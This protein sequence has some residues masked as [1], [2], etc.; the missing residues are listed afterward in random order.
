M[1]PTTAY[2]SIMALTQKAVGIIVTAIL[3]ALAGLTI[4]QVTLLGTARDMEAQTFRSGV[5]T[6][7]SNTVHGLETAE[8]TT[9]AFMMASGIDDS[10]NMQVVTS[11]IDPQ[12]L[13]FQK[14]NGL[15]HGL[16]GDTGLPTARWEGDT[17]IYLLTTPQRVKI[18][19]VGSE[20]RTDIVVLDT[21]L[22][23]GEHR[24]TVETENRMHNTYFYQFMAGDSAQTFQREFKIVDT[25]QRFGSITMDIEATELGDSGRYAFV[26]EIVARL[27]MFEQR[28]IVERIDTIILD[29]ILT[30]SL[31]EAGIPLDF[32]FGLFDS[33]R[34]S[35]VF[36]SD[37]LLRNDLSESEFKVGM[38]PYDF[39]SSQADLIV[40]F[41]DRDIFL[42]K[43]I[44]PVGLATIALMAVIVLVFSYT[45]KTIIDQRRNATLM[46]DF[47]NNMTHEFKTP[48]STV[49]LA[50]E[51]ILRSD[52]ID[53]KERVAKFGQMIQSENRRMRMQAEKI[54]QMAVLEEKDHRL[55]MEPV[56]FHNIINDATENATLRVE[57]LQGR[58]SSELTARQFIVM[59]DPLHLAG[60]INNLLDN[61]IKYSNESP[62]INVHSSVIGRH[63]ILKVSDQGIG[64][65]AED[66][67]R[68][69]D[70]Y[71]RVSSG[72]VHN[73]KGF[74]LGLS[75]VKLMVTAHGGEISVDST[76]G[77][78][79]T[80]R[81]SFPLHTVEG[82]EDRNG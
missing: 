16:M 54:L 77:E 12:L 9:T 57:S 73:V 25:T 5:Q 29:S 71:Y 60:I 41:P 74:G 45:I 8:V 69:F 1:I 62:V 2:I 55:K 11:E 17:V 44:W 30:A 72:N 15:F 67:K 22:E 81:V 53:D 75:Y 14:N 68:V 27:S 51:A 23:A 21:N 7:L 70:K 10:L 31:A 13:R 33:H 48:I 49:A 19:Q 4:V 82:S 3:L 36:A 46:V 47:V 42:W 78:G 59:A 26:N 50:S 80:F 18:E 38:F 40:F 56:N 6:A 52:V 63:L 37:S 58:I 65:K 43:Q 64:L 28:P 39:G 76:P 32:E 24:I 20:G 35:F 61:A 79:A 34:D 66:R